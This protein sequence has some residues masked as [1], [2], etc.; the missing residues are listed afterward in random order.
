LKLLRAGTATIADGNLIEVACRSC[1]DD[2]RREGRPVLVV[3]HRFGMDGAFV[4]TVA[5]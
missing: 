2:A 4:E 1:R 5:G 3:L